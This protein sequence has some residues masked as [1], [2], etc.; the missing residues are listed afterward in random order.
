MRIVLKQCTSENNR[1]TKEFN[2][3][4]IE[5]TGT[6]RESTSIL[7]P[8]IIVESSENLSAYNY[9]EIED[10]GRKYFITDITS[11][12]KN[13]WSISCRVDVLSTYKTA[14]GG[15]KAIVHRQQDK[16]KSNLYINDDQFY[17][18]QRSDITRHHFIKDGLNFSF[19]PDNYYYV[20]IVSGGNTVSNNT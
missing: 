13:L 16:S 10:F 20:L 14:I 8:T 9:M 1:I 7:R 12:R 17:I 5:L 18:E 11:V 3:N 4:V 19:N 2:N 6:L 15:C